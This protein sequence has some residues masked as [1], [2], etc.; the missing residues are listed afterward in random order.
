VVIEV[1]GVQGGAVVV[2]AVL[3]PP[4]EAPRPRPAPDT[5]VPRDLEQSLET[6]DFD[7]LGRDRGSET[8]SS[9]EH[10][11]SAPPRKQS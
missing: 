1:A 10:L 9:G 11:D 2:R 4:A 3:A 5:T 6:F 8:M 7:A